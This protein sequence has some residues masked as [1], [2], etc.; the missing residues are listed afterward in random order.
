MISI[1]PSRRSCWDI[2]R[3][4]EQVY[5]DRQASIREKLA[6]KKSRKSAAYTPMIDPF[7]GTIHCGH[8]P[9]LICIHANKI[10]LRGTNLELHY[11][12]AVDRSDPMH[13]IWEP[14]QIILSVEL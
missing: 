10:V 3:H 14:R 8:E 5:I 6:Y 4:V 12:I 1:L 11:Q 9:Y 2:A 13:P 7:N